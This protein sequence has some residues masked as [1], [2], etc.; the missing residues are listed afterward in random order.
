M[1]IF[2]HGGP[3][4]RDSADFEWWSQF[5]ASRGY[6]VL[7]PNFRGSAG[8][9]WKFQSAGFD[10]WG[11]AMQDDI[12][13]GVKA[14][15]A[16]GTADPRRICIV[17]AS[18]GGYAALAGAAFTPDLYRCAVSVEGVSN[19]IDFQ[20]S[21]K[22]EAYWTTRIG[23]VD[24]NTDALNA[25][26]PALHA[27]QV[28]VPILLMHG[29]KDV[30]VPI[31]QSFAGTRCVDE[32]GQDCLPRFDSTATST[33]STSPARASACCRKSRNS[34]TRISGIRRRHARPRKA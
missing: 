28:R 19:L 10:Q 3:E 21:G 11:R 7:Q 27:D 34:S 2:P 4:S 5:M 9:G 23:D 20:N 30:T 17:G 16:D 24:K 14:L 13:D 29:E 1:V 26:S 15:I 12:T 33:T 22:R 18:Y 25:A 8:Y 32:G 31:D 6:A